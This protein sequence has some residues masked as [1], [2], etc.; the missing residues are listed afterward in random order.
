MSSYA[1]HD[2]ISGSVT[3]SIGSEAMSLDGEYI[4][5]HIA[6]YRTLSVSGRESLEYDISDDDRR[7]DGQNYYYKRLPARILTIRFQ[8]IAADAESFMAQFRELKN[9]CKG[10]SRVI[11]FA[12]EPNAHYTGTLEKLEAPDPGRLS[13]TTTMTFYCADPYLVADEITTVTAAR[14]NGV[15]T[16][17]D[18]KSVV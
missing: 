11:R 1:F 9:F 3:H 6:G 4:E 16:A 8:L 17:E 2:T 13:I 7:S 15:L 5:N 14:V 12:D 10:E 18:R